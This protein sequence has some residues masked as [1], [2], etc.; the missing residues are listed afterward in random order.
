MTPTQ[1]ILSQRLAVRRTVAV[2]LIVL[3]AWVTWGALVRPLQL[4]YRAQ[5]GWRADALQELARGKALI[6]ISTTVDEQSEELS[7]SALWAK[8]YEDS[9]DGAAS[10]RL[11]AD[12]SEIVSSAGVDLQSMVPMTVV[13]GPELDEIGVRLTAS[14]TIDQLKSL[15]A[16]TL[17]HP[18]YLR[19]GYL[20]I[21]APQSQS[22]TVNPQLS[23]T[24]EVVGFRQA[25][26]LSVRRTDRT[27][28]SDLEG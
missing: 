7:A 9:G 25:A 18:R 27:N 10:G 13:F 2:L 17:R 19:I 21:S 8:L 16:A 20:A 5:A 26:G 15:L 11:Q 24:L 3:T 6:E 12:V 14:M 4:A 28:I 22:A 23:V 1:A